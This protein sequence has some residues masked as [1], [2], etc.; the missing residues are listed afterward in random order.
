MSAILMRHIKAATL[1]CLF[2]LCVR[3]H[4]RV[5]SMLKILVFALNK[6]NTVLS[7]CIIKTAINREISEI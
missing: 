1:M 6:L 2:H 5:H 4:F 3:V 7:L